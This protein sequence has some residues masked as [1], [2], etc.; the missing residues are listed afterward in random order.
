MIRKV[1]E[2]SIHEN[3]NNNIYLFI[4]M[5]RERYILIDFYFHKGTSISNEGNL[6]TL[7]SYTDHSTINIDIDNIT[8]KDDYFCFELSLDTTAEDLFES[9][10]RGYFPP[11]I[12]KE[13]ENILPFRTPSNDAHK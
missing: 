7:E 9:V 13:I 1:K 12:S 2:I 11:Y 5:L 3:E 4:G 8:T 10:L 6:Y